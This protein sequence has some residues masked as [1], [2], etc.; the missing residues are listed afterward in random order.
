ALVVDSAGNIYVAD[1]SNYTI[2]KITPGRVVTTLAGL[3]GSVGSSDG[4]GTVARFHYPEAIAL[5][6][7]GNLYVA[8][9]YNQTIRKISS[10]VVTTVAG[11]PGSTGAVDGTGSVARFNGTGGVAVAP[12][13]NLYVADIYNHTVRK[14]AT[15]GIVTTFAGLAGSSGSADGAG[16]AARFDNP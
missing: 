4:T 2:R 12:S 10:G 15:G 16:S 1:G 6:S 13:G 7:S 3:A 8:D 14:I 11:F 5:D 9:T